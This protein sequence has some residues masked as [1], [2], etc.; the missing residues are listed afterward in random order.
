MGIKQKFVML[1]GIVGVI[2]ALV[3]VIGYYTAYTNLADSVEK[4]IAAS[5]E[6]QSHETEGWLR[7]KAKIVTAE[8]DLMTQM[9]G[10]DVDTAMMRRMLSLAVSDM[11][12][13]EMT[14]G[15]EQGMFLPYYHP[16]ETGRTDPRQ[17][18]WY[19]Q[20]KAAGR[21]VYTEVYQSKSTGDLV[22][23]AAAPF[24]GKNHEFLGAICGDITLGVL[25]EQVKL[26]KYRERGQGY[27]IENTGKLLATAGDEEVMTEAGNL[28]GIGAH[29]EEM[30]HSGEGYFMY[31]AGQ[32]EQV[33]AYTTVPST[34]WIIGMSVPYDYVFGSVTRL[35]TTYILLT[36]AGLLLMLWLCLM[37]ASHITEPILALEERVAVI[38]HGDLSGEDVPVKSSDES[39]SLTQ[40]CNTMRSELRRLIGKV[41]VVSDQVSAASEELT[42]NAQ[43]SASGY[44]SVVESIGDIAYGMSQQILAVDGVK[45]GIDSLYVD[46][47]HMDEQA[48]AVS[49]VAE[50]AA[51]S[52]RALAVSDEHARNLLD[53]TEGINQAAEG[54]IKTVA[55]VS[56]CVTNIVMA[57]DEMD[58]V[59][60]KTA[61][62]AQAI[63]AVTE[64][65]SASHE[66]IASASNALA[67]MAMD[68]QHT[69]HK[70]KL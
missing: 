64:Q 42:A 33:F 8:A 35:K 37:F 13:Q 53:M 2:L 31:D 12:V 50:Q 56:E 32:G 34:G 15:D 6:A 25:Q 4:E 11:E 36:V 29:L 23:S 59:S 57:M 46:I 47:A 38:A 10:Q 9:A 14:R 65:Q 61:D 16:E 70:F 69:I 45:Q 27:I 55:S 26:I 54:M 58:T 30:L 48:S 66:E 3:S 52:V 68:M 7:E 39:G 63:S 40:G 62:H 51:D 19:I 18:P 21:T 17:R 1:A 41:E 67:E 28:P 44:I 60:R 24:Y 5:L 49:L 22:V 20:A 43:Q